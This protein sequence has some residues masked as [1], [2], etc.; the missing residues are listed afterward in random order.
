MAPR[1]EASSSLNAEEEALPFKT[2]SQRAWVKG[3]NAAAGAFAQLPA[4]VQRISNL[5]LTSR[6]DL[7]TCDGSLFFSRKDGATQTD[8]GTWMAIFLYQPTGETPKYV[9]LKK[10]PKTSV[11]V[12]AN[13]LLTK[14]SGGTLAAADYGYRVTA[15]DGE[16]GETPPCAEVTVTVTAGDVA[17]S[18]RSVKLDWDANSLAVG[19]YKVYGRTVSGELFIATVSTNT[20]T[21]TGSVTP[22]GAMPTVDTTEICRFYHITATSYDDATD[23]LKQFP[24]DLIRPDEDGGDVG[25]GGGSSGGG[26][27]GGGG[28]PATGGLAGNLSPLPQLVQFTNKVIL[29]LGNGHK[30]QIY[31]GSTTVDLTNTF[32]SSYPLW[33]AETAYNKDDVITPT[34]SNGH[35]YKCAQAGVTGSSQPTFPTGTD[36]TVRDGTCIWKEA[37]ADSAGDPPIAA[38]HGV[39]HAGALWVANTHTSNHANGIDG[40]SSIRMSDINNP[41]SWNPINHAFIGKDD[42]SEIMGL[43]QFTIA[44]SGIAPAGALVVFKQYSSYMVNGVFGSVNFSIQ[45]VQTDMGCIAPRSI[46]FL[47]GFG[48]ARLTHLGVAIFDGVRDR[49]ISEEIR[50][51]LFGGQSDIKQMDW[52]YAYFSKA[53]QC[54]TPPMYCLAIPVKPDSLSGLTAVD[55]GGGGS[56]AAGTY[57][58]QLIAYDSSGKV[59]AAS[60]LQS[61]SVTTRFDVTT[62]ALP[63]GAASFKLFYGIGGTYF[64]DTVAAGVSTSINTLG[65]KTRHPLGQ[66]TRLLCYDLV[67][68]AWTIIDLP[69][70][71]GSLQQT[72]VGGSIPITLFGGWD[73]ATVRRWQLGDTTWDGTPVSW[74]VITSNVFSQAPSERVYFRRVLVR[75]LASSAANLTITVQLNGEN[76][77]AVVA[78]EFRFSDG[79]FEAV[80]DIHRTALNANV[81][82]AGSGVCTLQSVD[83]HLMGK[84]GMPA[85]IA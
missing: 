41:N 12:P 25:G 16:G 66:L 57:V 64:A 10:D 2:T 67:L 20:Y 26:G 19:G 40:P 85:R 65:T 50:P 58:L 23:T 49:L 39:V 56:L 3:I 54:A 75:G 31:D 68:K 9:G 13:L 48:I 74:H 47:P 59:V 83:W 84:P 8:E 77:M 69:Y 24:A 80:V 79:Q 76:Q 43:S 62:P 4:T 36:R 52:S 35:I 28:T 71:I 51:Y 11:G 33:T 15:L 37:G 1:V 14:I 5:L 21:D 34:V 38:A 32:V 70:G 30:P 17:G 61:L 81:K 6:G 7:K 72:R 78:K 53:A 63:T 42:G 45:Q 82:V 55:G 27:A 60:P 18:I 29:C 73:D 22:A 44:E 46:V